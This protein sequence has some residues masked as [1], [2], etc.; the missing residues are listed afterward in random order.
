M[1]EPQAW[2]QAASSSC[3]SCLDG[4]NICSNPPFVLYH[5]FL[6]QLHPQLWAGNLASLQLYLMTQVGGGLTRLAFVFEYLSFC[7]DAYGQ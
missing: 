2:L 4:S 5:M 6:D 7:R 1:K 3:Y